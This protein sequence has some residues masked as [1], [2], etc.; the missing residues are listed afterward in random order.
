MSATQ[1]EEVNE[2]MRHACCGNC[3]F[4]RRGGK[5]SDHEC[6]RSP[7]VRTRGL[8]G[9]VRDGWPVVSMVDSCG[10]FVWKAK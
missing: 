8:L 9:T 5:Y 4:F 2:R 1:Q 7:P 3:V 6:R 10:E